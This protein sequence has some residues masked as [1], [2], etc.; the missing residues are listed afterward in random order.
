[1]WGAA[2]AR[3]VRSGPEGAT[4]APERVNPPLGKPQA[5]SR[6]AKLADQGFNRENNVVTR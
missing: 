1:L 6:L 5:L 3:I 4:L 2:G